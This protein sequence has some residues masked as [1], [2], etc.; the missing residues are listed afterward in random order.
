MIG[1]DSTPGLVVFRL[2]TNTPLFSFRCIY[3]ASR[4]EVFRYET[5]A[6]GNHWWRHDLPDPRVVDDLITD[7]KYFRTFMK[8]DASI[9][10][11]TS[12]P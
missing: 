7:P 3:L 6:S 9:K 4:Q 1:L 12:L 8:Q 11:R 2:T 5:V 10:T